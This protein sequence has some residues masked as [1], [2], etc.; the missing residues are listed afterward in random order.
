MELERQFVPLSLHK[1]F[2]ADGP[3]ASPLSSEYEDVDSPTEVLNKFDYIS[4]DKGNCDSFIK[5]DS[6][7]NL[8]TLDVGEFSTLILTV[9]SISNG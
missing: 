4:Y 1:A 5:I 6:S 9:V 7:T 2:E 3:E 8:R